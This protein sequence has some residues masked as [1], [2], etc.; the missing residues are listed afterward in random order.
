[1]PKKGK[2]WGGDRHERGIERKTEE[3]GNVNKKNRG[4]GK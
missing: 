2:G 1:M 4:E 3:M